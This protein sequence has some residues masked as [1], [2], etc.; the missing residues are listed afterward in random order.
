PNSCPLSMDCPVLRSIQPLG[1]AHV[2]AVSAGDAPAR[3]C[4]ADGTIT[5]AANVADNT[6]VQSLD[7]R[8]AGGAEWPKACRRDPIRFVIFHLLP[9]NETMQQKRIFLFLVQSMRHPAL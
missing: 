3:V 9:G 8:I 7:V 6:Q 4:A 5:A 1:M 2:E